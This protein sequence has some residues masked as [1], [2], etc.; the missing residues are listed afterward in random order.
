MLHFSFDT[1]N[2]GRKSFELPGAKPHYNPDRPGQVEHLFLD[3]ELDI[4]NQRYQGTCSI[5]LNPVQSG[6]DRLTLDA[7]HLNI[8]SVTVGNTA[9][10]FDHDG[11]QLQIKLQA[12][13]E[14][15]KPIT[16]AIAYS[17]DHPQRGLYFITPNPHYPNKPTQVWTQGEDEDSRFWFPCFDY[18]GQLATSEIRVRV[19]Q[20]FVAISNGELVS[21]EEDG[22]DKIYHWVQKQVHPTYLMTLAVGDFAEIRDEWQGR[23]VTYYVEKGREADARRTMG[24]TPRMI[25]FFSQTFGYPYPY[26]KYAQVCVDDFIFGGMENTSTTLLTDRCLLDERAALD[27]RN[28]ESLVAHELAHQWFGDLVVI[29]HWSHAW[30]KEGMASY[31]EVLWTDY[32]YGADEAAYYLLNEARSYL[33]EDSSRYRRPIVTHIYREAIELYDRHLYEKGAC[34]YHMIRAALSDQLFAKAIH[35]FV[36]DNAHQ[37]VETVDLLRAIDKATGRN[38][39]FLF[40]QYVFRGGHPDY[41]V[42]YAWDGDS[43][44]AKITITQTQAKEGDRSS[45]SGLFDLKIPIGFGYVETNQ[46]K[47]LKTFTVRIHER[48]QSFYFPLPKPQFISFDVG[49]HTLKTVTLEYPLAELKSQVQFDPDPISRI[50]AVEA[51]A[52]KGGLEAVT[53]LSHA[54]ENEAFWGVRA[55]I[56]SQLASVKLDQAFEGLVKGLKDLNSRVRRSTVEALAKFKTNESYNA[57]ESIAQNGDVSYYVEAASVRAIGT[58]AAGLS[59][60]TATEGEALN[61]LQSALENRA[62]WNETV[63]SGAIAGLSQMKTSE[64][65][66]D[67]VLKYTTSGVPQALRLSAIRALGAISTGQSNINVER[68]LNRL[69]ELSNETFFLTQVAVVVAL[70]QMETPSAIAILQSLADQT[71]DGRVR[72]IAEEAIQRVQKAIGSDKAVK[73]LQE[74][75]DQLKKDNQ[76]LRSR[77]ESLEARAK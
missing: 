70:G 67:L 38:L 2:N 73:K 45:N 14:A 52:K 16:V 69:E 53:V 34:V 43:N 33:D 11:E 58:I 10:D 18:P 74:E 64:V 40:D 4:P 50:Y 36:Q 72:R 25:E 77:L 37:T 47:E 68:I 12:A 55:E 1:D 48:E 7:V 5:R 60:N 54:L 8:I 32:E 42:A 51:L 39:Q 65:A 21:T 9:Q 20:P 35:T 27:N 26:P 28:A 41:T 71:P 23:P 56:A 19:S 49:N 66:L 59:N 61:L 30:L 24:K 3:L 62:G 46:F 17:V 44:L 6:I 13:T 63:R 75:V 15:G 31:S 29:K 76:E 57:I 22:N